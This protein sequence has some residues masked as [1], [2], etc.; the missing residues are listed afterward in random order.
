[1]SKKL[2]AP[3]TQLR[4]SEIELILERS[5]IDDW[6]EGS[7]KYRDKLLKKAWDGS[8]K[9]AVNTGGKLFLRSLEKLGVKAAGEKADLLDQAKELTNAYRENRHNANQANVQLMKAMNKLNILGDYLAEIATDKVFLERIDNLLQSQ[10]DPESQV[11]LNEVKKSFVKRQKYIATANNARLKLKTPLF[12]PLFDVDF[13]RNDFDRDI[14]ELKSA[15]LALV[16]TPQEEEKVKDAIEKKGRST[17]LKPELDWKKDPTSSHFRSI[18]ELTVMKNWLE[19]DMNQKDPQKVQKAK[20]FTTEINARTSGANRG[21]QQDTNESYQPELFEE[22][23]ENFVTKKKIKILE[24]EDRSEY[25]EDEDGNVSSDEE[26]DSNIAS[27]LK[28]EYQEFSKNITEVQEGFENFLT[29]DFP[30]HVEN[31]VKKW[32]KQISDNSKEKEDERV[33]ALLTVAVGN[34]KRVV[35]LADEIANEY[36]IIH[37]NLTTKSSVQKLLPGI[38][39]LLSKVTAQVKN[40]KSGNNLNNRISANSVRPDDKNLSPYVQS[41]LHEIFIMHGV[42]LLLFDSYVRDSLSNLDDFFTSNNTPQGPLLKK[43]FKTEKKPFRNL[44]SVL[45]KYNKF[46]SEF[47]QHTQNLDSNKEVHKLYNFLYDHL[48]LAKAGENPEDKDE[49]LFHAAVSHA[50]NKNKKESYEHIKGF[51]DYL[52]NL[53]KRNYQEF[54]DLSKQK[55]D[56]L[57]GRTAFDIRKIDRDRKAAMFSWGPHPELQDK[58]DSDLN[59]YNAKDFSWPKF[60][61]DKHLYFKNPELY[62]KQT[63]AHVIRYIQ[64]LSLEQKQ[65]KWEEYLASKNKKPKEDDGEKTTPVIELLKN[66]KI[67]EYINENPVILYTTPKTWQ[68]IGNVKWK[69]K[70]KQVYNH[71]ERTNY[72][73][74]EELTNEDGTGILDQIQPEELKKLRKSDIVGFQIPEINIYD[75]EKVVKNEESTSQDDKKLTLSLDILALIAD[76]Y[77]LFEGIVKKN[78]K[79][80]FIY[81]QNENFQNEDLLKSLVSLARDFTFF[82]EAV[83]T[84]DFKILFNLSKEKINKVELFK[85]LLKEDNL[86]KVKLTIEKWVEKYGSLPNFSGGKKYKKLLAIFTDI[87][88]QITKAIQERYSEKLYILSMLFFDLDQSRKTRVADYSTDIISESTIEPSDSQIRMLKSSSRSTKTKLEGRDQFL[89]A[90]MKWRHRM[91][92]IDKIKEEDD[93]IKATSKEREERNKNN[94]SS[95]EAPSLDEYKYKPLVDLLKD[96]Y[97]HLGRTTARGIKS[98]S[99][100]NKA[101]S[102]FKRFHDIPQTFSLTSFQ[103]IITDGEHPDKSNDIHDYVPRKEYDQKQKELIHK[104]EDLQKIINSETNLL[105]SWEDLDGEFKSVYDLDKGVKETNHRIWDTILKLQR[106]N[107]NFKR[108]NPVNRKSFIS[109][110]IPILK[111]LTETYVTQSTALL[112]FADKFMNLHSKDIMKLLRYRQSDPKHSD[113]PLKRSPV[114]ESQWN[115]YNEVLRMLLG[116]VNSNGELHRNPI[117]EKLGAELKDGTGSYNPEDYLEYFDSDVTGLNIKVDTSVGVTSDEQLEDLNEKIKKLELFF[118]KMDPDAKLLIKKKENESEDEYAERKE[119]IEDLIKKYDNKHGDEVLLVKNF[120]SKI[121]NKKTGNMSLEQFYKD[122]KHYTRVTTLVN[123]KAKNLSQHQKSSLI[124]ISCSIAEV[125]SVSNLDQREDNKLV[126]I[127]EQKINDILKLFIQK[128]AGTDEDEKNAGTDAKHI[129]KEY[130]KKY[131]AQVSINESFASI[132]WR[133]NPRTHLNK[134]TMVCKNNEYKKSLNREINIAGQKVKETMCLPKSAK[135]AVEKAKDRKSSLKRWKTVRSNPGKMKIAKMK[136]NLTRKYSKTLR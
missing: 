30:Q 122:D 128:F 109:I 14:L 53:L 25:E 8:R 133:K 19:Q 57:E 9:A 28:Q 116:G 42:S 85:F 111:A 97:T 117:I 51:A 24:A 94:A 83:P 123:N 112:S 120:M 84:S 6:I 110:L 115:H 113:S 32:R 130:F 52:A 93:E 86:K 41:I 22:L 61:E 13:L 74:F 34:S 90:E 73:K 96:F 36:R 91:E 58:K 80:V 67:I 12:K 45:E 16:D 134:V 55:L 119:K 7:K 68:K 104:K 18:T 70:R 106:Q 10:F 49:G 132:R 129:L 43:S 44:L 101:L 127:P 102:R 23:F 31:A 20:E 56:S 125:L 75:I 71:I 47:S 126:K 64:S 37:G 72:Y 105:H 95:Y 136:R 76:N 40:L 62:G 98:L 100:Y 1:M 63:P 87:E 118:D 38:S 124:I 15:G 39:S 114:T 60:I 88:K 50:A 54:D 108:L 121:K 21:N 27:E 65:S 99:S 107:E 81:E 89:S 4:S 78:K 2:Q 33:D 131:K 3:N 29:K 46:V 11:L 35:K 77:S 59:E 92:T 82:I 69:E 103:K 17:P 66:D 26:V 48:Y 79:S 135:P 5:F